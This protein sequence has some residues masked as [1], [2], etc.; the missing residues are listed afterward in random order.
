M[1]LGLYFDYCLGIARTL[2]APRCLLCHAPC[3]P[4]AVCKG[5]SGEFRRLAE[6]L[7]RQCATPL[8]HG[9]LCGA[10]LAAPPRYDRLLAAFVYA[11][12]LDAMIQALKYG[13]RLVVIRPLAEALAA[14]VDE[15]VD[16][17]VPM[18]LSTARL[19]E[20]GR[21]HV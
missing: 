15:R 1:K 4:H 3:G 14:R 19:R 6:P 13:R 11:F 9:A 12:P 7:C 16:L 20:I 8:P 10:C 5:C 17:I 18:P 21:A 2:A